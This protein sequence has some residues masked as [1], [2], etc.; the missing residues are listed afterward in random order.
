MRSAGGVRR[1]IVFKRRMKPAVVAVVGVATALALVWVAA[2]LS[3]GFAGTRTTPSGDFGPAIFGGVLL[4]I[5][6]WG[7]HLAIYAGS[8]TIDPRGLTYRRRRRAVQYPWDDLARIEIRDGDVLALPRQMSALDRDLRLRGI[9]TTPG[10][11]VR[12][13]RMDELRAAPTQVLE[14]IAE[15]RPYGAV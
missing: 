2:G 11:S 3:I 7:L 9:A 12:V 14:A 8:L 5:S 6:G 10:G 4:V 15:H 1:P 13:C